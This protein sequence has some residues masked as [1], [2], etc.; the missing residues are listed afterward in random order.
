M[1]DMM[2]TFDIL[3]PKC[4]KKYYSARL[5]LLFQ[6]LFAKCRTRLVVYLSCVSLVSHE[7]CRLN[8]WLKKKNIC[9][10]LATH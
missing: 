5:L 9:Y 10:E 7:E 6:V 1:R 2:D 4:S 3:F 8:H